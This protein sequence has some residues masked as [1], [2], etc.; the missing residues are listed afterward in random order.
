MRTEGACAF[1]IDAL[2]SGKIASPL[3]VGK[4]MR[5]SLVFHAAGWKPPFIDKIDK[6]LPVHTIDSTVAGHP[7]T[8]SAV[9]DDSRNDIIEQAVLCCDCFKNAP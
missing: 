8:V 3:T 7:K 5:P 1:A 9:I 2:A 4:R 6:K